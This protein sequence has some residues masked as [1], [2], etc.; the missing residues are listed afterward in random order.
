M[1]WKHSLLVLGTDSPLAFLLGP[2]TIAVT[3]RFSAT[4][5]M[6]PN[7]R[8]VDALAHQNVMVG[9][10]AKEPIPKF[11]LMFV[12]PYKLPIKELREAG[13]VDAV[14]CGDDAIKL[15]QWNALR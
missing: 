2:D 3:R 6:A 10:R 11:P 8:F 4:G 13:L 9:Y 1:D 14:S 12:G 7:S 15:W 5:T